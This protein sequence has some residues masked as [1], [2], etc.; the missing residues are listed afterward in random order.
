MV[1]YYQL[2][3]FNTFKK[4]YEFYLLDNNNLLYFQI[5]SSGETRCRFRA[6][7]N[8]FCFLIC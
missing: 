2:K 5:P 1:F 3:S 7:G 8:I 6:A 4:L